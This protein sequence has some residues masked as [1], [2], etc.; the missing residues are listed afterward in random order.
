MYAETRNDWAENQALYGEKMSSL[1]DRL[2]TEKPELVE[3]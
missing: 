3:P 2:A 1:E